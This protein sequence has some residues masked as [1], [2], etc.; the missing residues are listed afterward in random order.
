MSTVRLVPLF[1]FVYNASIKTKTGLC[2]YTP[3][4]NKKRSKVNIKLPLIF[5]LLSICSSSISATFN[6]NNNADTGDSTPGD[7]ICETSTNNNICTLRAAIDETNSLTGPDTIFLPAD[8]YKIQ[9]S[10]AND[11]SSGSF[12]ISDGLTLNGENV[13]TTVI[14]GESLDRVFYIN[15]PDHVRI[16]DITIEKGNSGFSGSGGGILFSNTSL[17]SV[18]FNCV[19]RNN[20]AQTGA[21]VSWGSPVTAVTIENSVIENNTGISNAVPAYS[22]G[23][24][25]YSGTGLL[26]LSKST[27]RNNT[28]VF[29]GGIFS[30]GDIEITRSTISGNTATNQTSNNAQAGGGIHVGS[31]SAATL[32]STNST[33]SGNMSYGSGA[34][35][36]AANGTVSLYNTTITNNIADFDNDG[37][38]EAGG[39]DSSNMFDTQSVQ[40]SNSIV[41]GNIS[42]T[43]VYSDCKSRNFNISSIGYNIIGDNTDCNI[44][45]H[46]SDLAG[47]TLTNL[48][49]PLLLTLANNG[50]L[51]QTHKLKQNSPAID[52]GNPANC[53]GHDGSILLLDQTGSNR[54]MDGFLLTQRCDIGAFELEVSLNIT[55]EGSIVIEDNSSSGAFNPLLSIFI[56]LTLLTIRGKRV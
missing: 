2:M 45:T 28:S 23:A 50:G 30:I 18:I 19:I 49:D 4:N 40:L 9:T 54:H 35:I 47:T 26:S 44:S 41:A 33:I 32:I 46:V 8:V 13:S 48:I 17:T 20:N 27:V 29:G 31:G 16:T 1:G 10:A 24:G 14:S 38:G 6:V 36:L 52:A 51:T 25:I 42:N 11:N 37:T 34:G 39:I 56:F 15:S 22:A 53:L 12:Y 5:I 43:G 3:Y 7:G 55:A 21:G